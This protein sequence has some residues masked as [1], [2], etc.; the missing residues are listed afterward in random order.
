MNELWIHLPGCILL[1]KLRIHYES[2]DRGQRFEGQSKMNFFGLVLHGF[3]GL[4]VF[5]EDVLVRAGILFFSIA[6]LAVV[7][8]FV[9]FLVRFLGEP[10]SEWL[11][12]VFGIIFLVFLQTG[13]LTLMMLILAGVSR[14]QSVKENYKE[15]IQSTIAPS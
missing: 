8:I 14:G 12:I 3:R 1:S 15:Y 10:A 11:S 6:A 5:V 13:S 2:I 7:F 4:M 9:A